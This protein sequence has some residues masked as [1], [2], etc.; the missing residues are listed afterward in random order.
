MA[1]RV[2]SDAASQSAPST[3]DTSRY[4]SI[5][6]GKKVLLLI[7]DIIVTY[8]TLA[9]CIWIVRA[10]METPAAWVFLV[11]VPPI[12]GLMLFLN[13]ALSVDRIADFNYQG[14]ALLRSSVLAV[15]MTAFFVYIFHAGPDISRKVLLIHGP[16]NLV[17]L[18]GWHYLFGRILVLRGFQRTVLVIGAGWAGKTIV[19]EL[20]RF[21]SRGFNVVGFIDD[22]KELF[23]EIGNVQVLGHSG[24]IDRIVR[25]RGVS[26][27]VLAITHERDE[28]VLRALQE[29]EWKGV[30]VVSMPTLYE[31]L[32]GKVPVKHINRYWLTFFNNHTVEHPVYAVAQRYINIALAL[33]GLILTLPIYP[34]VMLLIKW[35]DPGPIFYCQERVGQNDQVFTLYKFRTMKVDA[36]NGQAQ[37]AQKD[38][39]RVTR[40]GKF[41]RKT[42]IDELPQLWNILRG[43]MNLVGP[44]PERPEFVR[45]LQAK[46]PFY[47]KRHL[48]KPGV[49]G[50]SQVQY[51][52][53]S[54]FEHAL[55]KLQYDLCY[56]KNRSVFLDLVICLKTVAVVLTGKGAQ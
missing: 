10:N 43:D 53:G 19:K 23:N 26:L 56:I 18:G 4:R 15:L 6:P 51:G 33:I 42:R 12:W 32:T 39:P 41:L 46:I 49:T 11:M 45:D 37:W 29:C 8:G 44:R 27:I 20:L 36:E 55:E 31:K 48:V 24:D 22:G 1:V 14:D 9:L 47:S 28:V 7:S 2:Q 16:M 52:Y 38:D 30:R 17:F 40:I 35:L 50:W 3:I 13:G 34:I 5:I 54:S 21:P 25:E